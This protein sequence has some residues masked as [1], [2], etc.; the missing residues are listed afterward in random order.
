MTA[1]ERKLRLSYHRTF[2]SNTDGRDVLLDLMQEAA[3]RFRDK[4]GKVQPEYAHAQC[5][6]DEFIT[7]IETMCGINCPAAKLALIE[8]EAGVAGNYVVPKEET[9]DEINLDPD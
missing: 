9:Q 1:E 5:T 7:R 2:L 6:L 4:D 3:C 8:A